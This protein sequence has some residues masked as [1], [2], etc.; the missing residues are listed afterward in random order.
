MRTSIKSQLSAKKQQGEQA[1]VKQ[2]TKA[3][4]PKP[5][6]RRRSPPIPTASARPPNQCLPCYNK[7]Q[8]AWEQ[9]CA[10]TGTDGCQAHAATSA[11]RRFSRGSA[12]RKSHDQQGTSKCQQWPPEEAFETAPWHC[13][14]EQHRPA[15]SPPR[16]TGR[17]PGRPPCSRAGSPGSSSCGWPRADLPPSRAACGTR[18]RSRWE[19]PA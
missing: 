16:C 2:T 14:C 13:R 7:E 6:S 1:R 17:P 5:T 19:C 9:C 3:R 15:R 12:V 11:A 4:V 10:Q 8:P 18:S